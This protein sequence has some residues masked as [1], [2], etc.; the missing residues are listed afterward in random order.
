MCGISSIYM[1][2][3]D[4]PDCKVNPRLSDY[5]IRPRAMINPIG[6]NDKTMKQGLKAEFAR[7]ARLVII[8]FMIFRF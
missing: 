7:L 8:D 4:L 2:R 1:D 6:L 5:C 3:F